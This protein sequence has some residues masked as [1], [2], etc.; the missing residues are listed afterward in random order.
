M[1]NKYRVIPAV[2]QTIGLGET[3]SI[4]IGVPAMITMVA[5]IWHSLSTNQ[6][7]IVA[8]SGTV[9]FVAVGLFIYGQLRK[10]L[11]VIPKILHQ[12]H[13]RTVELAS[14]LNIMTLPQEDLIK[15]MS[16]V[17]IDATQLYSS[18]KDFESVLSSVPE[19]IKIAEKQSKKAKEEEET[20]QRVFYLM[21]EKIGL[22]N[23]LETD[24]QYQKLKGK[25]DKI[26]TI[27]PTEEINQAILEYNKT[28]RIVGTFLP[29]FTTIDDRIVQILP[30]EYNIDRTRKIEQLDGTMTL[31]LSKIW[32]CIGKYYKGS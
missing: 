4:I 2:V 26:M 7:I 12:M 29:M 15:L 14:H 18:I 19:L 8:I 16:L 3:I 6:Q 9:I 10:A 23:A 32:E 22:K 21:Y 24:K 1:S 31:L 5:N 30:L 17:S 20:P 11:Y 13:L 25:L 27:V 28:S